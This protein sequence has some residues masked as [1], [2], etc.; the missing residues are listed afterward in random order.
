MME[1]DAKCNNGGGKK[2][3]SVFCFFPTIQPQ[4]SSARI[5]RKIDQINVVRLSRHT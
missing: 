4:R 5:P 2:K 3:K 1:K